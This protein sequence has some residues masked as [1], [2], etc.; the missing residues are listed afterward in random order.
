MPR[1]AKAIKNDVA[2]R[3]IARPGYHATGDGLY[4]QI[5]PSGTRSWIFRFSFA[6][7]RHEMGL[8]AYPVLALKDARAK[9][10]EYRRAIADGRNPLQERR[11]AAQAAGITFE[12]AAERYLAAHEASW[13]NPKHRQQWRNTLEAYALPSIGALPVATIGVQHVI[14]IL[15]LLWQEKTETAS[16][17]RG[18]IESVLDWC[19]ARGYRHGDNPARW[20]GHLDKL[21]PK[22]SKVQ[23]VQ[24]HAALPYAELPAFYARLQAQ[25]GIAALAL[26][27][28][29]L[30]AARTGEVIGARW[31]EING[32]VWNVPATRMKAG[33][34]HRVPLSEEALAIL[35][36]VRP[37]ASGADSFLFPGMRKGSG[38]SNMSMSAALKRMGHGDITVHGFRSAFRDWCSETTAYPREVCEA[39]LA[40]VN[41]DRVEAAYLRS[42]LFERRRRL[43]GDWGTFC[44]KPRSTAAVVGIGEGRIAAQGITRSD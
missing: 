12:E 40:H 3:A 30:T 44:T 28:T 39:A 43:M 1:Q 15:E 27:F 21:L 14:G 36:A 22:R 5:T 33:R 37:L 32:A 25:E 20:R 10:M 8:G 7:K 35:E 6:G 11:A 13:R 34:P 29:I 26:R 41:A 2:L 17:L 16:R 38:L 9:A 42:D 18:R 24:H 4:L 31:Q 23:R 19:T